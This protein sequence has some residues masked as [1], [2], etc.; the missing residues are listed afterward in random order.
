MT[1]REQ[2]QSIRAS[3]PPVESQKFREAK[4]WGCRPCPDVDPTLSE[5]VPSPAG[6]YPRPGTRFGGLSVARYSSARVGT[7]RNAAKALGAAP[8]EE[9]GPLGGAEAAPFPAPGLP[10][11]SPPSPYYLL[12]R[13]ASGGGHR[14]FFRSRPPPPASPPPL[15]LSLRSHPPLPPRPAP[16][17]CLT[18]PLPRFA[19]PRRPLGS[20][21]SRL[22]P[23]TRSM[24]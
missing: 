4:G 7:G 17:P 21:P 16:A 22:P 23:R 12:P 20:H 24:P 10:P 3:S 5:T 15:S 2:G 8:P 11:S 1:L 19:A 14:M 18:P 13:R 6:A 9:E